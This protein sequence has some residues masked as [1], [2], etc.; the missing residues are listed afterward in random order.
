LVSI[1]VDIR[2]HFYWFCTK[3]NTHTLLYS[4]SFVRNIRWVCWV[5][6][7]DACVCVFCWDFGEG[8]RKN[9]GLV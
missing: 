5:N 2:F 8:T 6:V 4:A 7:F 9:Q 3:L 1:V